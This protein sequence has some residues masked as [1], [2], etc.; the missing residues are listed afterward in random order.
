[1]KQFQIIILLL[2]VFFGG[3]TAHCRYALPPEVST[4]IKTITDTDVAKDFEVESVTYSGPDKE[5]QTDGFKFQLKGKGLQ[6]A[7]GKPVCVWYILP[8]NEL[9]YASTFQFPNLKTDEDFTVDFII[10]DLIKLS[11]P[12]PD[13]YIRFMPEKF[14]G[15]VLTY[16]VPSA[17]T[18]NPNAK[19]KEIKAGPDGE[20]FTIVEVTAAFP[21]GINGIMKYLSKNI[22]YPGEAYRKNIHG[23]VIVQFIIN[24][25]GKVTEPRV[26][27]GID[28]SLDAEALRVAGDMP[29][30]LPGRLCGKPVKSYFILP[31][32]FR[33]QEL[34]SKEEKKQFK[35]AKKKMKE[36]KKAEKKRQKEEKK[37]K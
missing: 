9:R 27:K 2:T 6:Q 35:E 31:I 36:E 3:L 7:I 22:K 16:D 28:E 19:G 13:N 10:Q 24:E 1:M 32:S 25:E 23:R 18:V 37:K 20:T 4:T 14:D 21:G 30:W 26:V 29:D 34:M 12:I 11:D 33:L 5:G 17:D 15:F 8:E